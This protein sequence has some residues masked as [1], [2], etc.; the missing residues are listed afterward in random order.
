MA[1]LVT[2]KTF[3]R[4]RVLAI[5]CIVAFLAAVKALHWKWSSLLLF[6][7]APLRLVAVAFTT[8][9]AT[10]TSLVETTAPFSLVA[11]HLQ[12]L[13]LLLHAG[14]LFI[15]LVHSLDLI[16]LAHLWVRGVLDDNVLLHLLVGHISFNVVVKLLSHSLESI[17]HN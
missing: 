16:H 11:S 8:L 17:A 14:N 10:V 7:K 12:C 5:C 3:L 1:W 4:C 2:R 9:V 13:Y 6:A 15:S